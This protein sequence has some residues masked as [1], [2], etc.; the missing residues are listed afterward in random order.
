MK[1]LRILLVLLLASATGNAWGGYLYTVTDLG[2]LSGGT[3][4]VALGINNKGQVVGYSD[5]A[6]GNNHAFLYSG[7]VLTDLGVLSGGVW[8]QAYSINDNGV[9]VGA[10][11]PSAGYPDA[12]MY[13]SG[14]M[15]Y[16]GIEGLANSI[17][18]SGQIVGDWQAA[19]YGFLQ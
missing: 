18:N 15:Q 9:I 19:G 1:N 6:N 3:E 12:F 11:W 5:T 13:S 10:S 8:S 16:F 17:N 14:S 7:G 4:S 2:V